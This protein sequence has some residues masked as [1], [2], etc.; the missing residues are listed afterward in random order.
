MKKLLAV[1]SL[2]MMACSTK[3][4]QP[5]AKDPLQLEEKAPV[6]VQQEVAE[7]FTMVAHKHKNWT[8]SIPSTFKVVS[9]TETD[10]Q[11]KTEDGSMFEFMTAPSTG[12]TQD[13]AEAVIAGFI[14]EKGWQPAGVRNGVVDRFPA[15]AIFYK[16]NGAVL[17]FLVFSTGHNSFSLLYAGVATKSRNEMFNQAAQSITVS[18]P[19]PKPVAPTPTPKPAKK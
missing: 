3:T 18:D 5:V 1:L 14:I 13:L 19:D 7:T 2:V 4:V 9:E 10:L 8:V 12:T 11:T 15:T 16:G 17:S 6:V